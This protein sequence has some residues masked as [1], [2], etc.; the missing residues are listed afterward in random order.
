[1]VGSWIK[2]NRKW[3]FSGVGVMIIGIAASIVLNRNS[4][5]TQLQTQSGTGN[6]QAGRDITV[7][8][9]TRSKEDA[10]LEVTNVGFTHEAEFDV[11]V[12]NLG[13]ID[14]VITK[15]TIKKVTP[16]LG[17]VYPILH[18]TAEYH[19][20]VDDIPVGKSKSIDVSHVVPPNKADRF[21]IALHTTT[22]YKLKVTLE[23]NRG[24]T[25][26]FEKRTW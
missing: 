14:L 26:Y 6:I 11:T 18:P 20:P 5:P 3:V 1:M 13:D 17:A 15:I 21:L 12:R 25:V 9:Q 19:I 7:V 24:K 4:S 23:Y 22:V 2:E 10:I 8:N 16:A